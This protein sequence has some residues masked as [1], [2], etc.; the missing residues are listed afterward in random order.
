VRSQRKADRQLTEK[1]F[2]LDAASN[3]AASNDARADRLSPT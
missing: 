1:L 2:R 3:D